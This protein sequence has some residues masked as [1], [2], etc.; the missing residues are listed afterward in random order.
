VCVCVCVRER[1]FLSVCVWVCGK[2]WQSTKNRSNN[3][4]GNYS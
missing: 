3:N 2:A 4:M 1:Q